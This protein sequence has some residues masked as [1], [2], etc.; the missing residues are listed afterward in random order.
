MW[1][2]FGKPDYN[3]FL[4]PLVNSLEKFNAG[5]ITLTTASDEA[6]QKTVTPN[7]ICLTAVVDLIE[8]PGLCKCKQF[9]GEYG[10]GYCLQKGTINRTEQKKDNSR[11]FPFEDAPERDIEKNLELGLLAIETGQAQ[12]G[13]VG[14]PILARLLHFSIIWS[15]VVDYMHGVC[16][17]VN[18][19]TLNLWFSSKNSK[20]SYYQGSA[21]LRLV[22]DR[23]RAIKPPQFITRVPRSMKKH[24][25]YWKA[26][27]HLNW[28][29][30]YSPI[31]LKG[32]LPE[33]LYVH[34][35]M[36][37][38]ALWILLGFS[39]SH[40]GLNQ[41]NRL[42]T[43]FY[44]SYEKFYGSRSCSINVH[45]LKYLVRIVKKI[46]PLWVCSCFPFESGNG[47]LTSFLNGTNNVIWQVVYKSSLYINLTRSLDNLPAKF[48]SENVSK[49]LEKVNAIQLNN[50]PKTK[51]AKK[52]SAICNLWGLGVSKSV[53]LTDMAQKDIECLTILFPGNELAGVKIFNFRRIWIEGLIWRSKS[54]TRSKVRINHAVSYFTSG[55]TQAQ[56]GR[57]EKFLFLEEI[58]KLVAVI[59]PIRRVP[60]S[61]TVTQSQLE[62]FNEAIPGLVPVIGLNDFSSLTNS[63]VWVYRLSPSDPIIAVPWNNLIQTLIYIEIPSMQGA[64]VMYKHIYV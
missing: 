54:Y 46:G 4:E 49:F 14:I 31:V 30:Y 61:S 41:A 57:L 45:H 28:I 56:F 48:F 12:K 36:L 52:L 8:K 25:K 33:E 43:I 1:F 7:V 15:V 10:C 34:W 13:V 60:L 6:C 63:L 50:R 27:E 20:Q 3:M 47:V 19:S 23:L 58:D 55:S 64:Y 39:I 42:L 51:S 9:N 38:A 22:D 59:T 17:G 35:M 24:L 26:A 11:S 32:V 5:Q 21:K 44:Y 62:K 16:L 2:G 40:D 37:V 18:R 53:N 29:L